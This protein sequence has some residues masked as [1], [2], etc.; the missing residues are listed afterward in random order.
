M[1]T[2]VKAVLLIVWDGIKGLLRTV[3]LMLL[4]TV[5]FGC[6]M[7]LMFGMWWLIG[8]IAQSIVGTNYGLVWLLMPTTS[9][10]TMEVGMSYS[11]LVLIPVI[12]VTTTVIIV[13]QVAKAFRTKLTEISPQRETANE[14]DLP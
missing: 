4:A 9:P 13:D 10:D 2:K 5:G 3:G 8:Y 6:L 1:N 12:I 11:M 14:K 7:G